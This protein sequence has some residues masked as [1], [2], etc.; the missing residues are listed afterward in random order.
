M[1]FI[2]FFLFLIFWV[3]IMSILSIFSCINWYDHVFFFFYWQLIWWIDWLLNIEQALHSWDKRHMS[4]IFLLRHCWIR[5][6]NI[7]WWLFHLCSWGLLVCSFFL[8]DSLQGIFGW[9]CYQGNAHLKNWV[10]KHS[11][12]GKRH[13][14][15]G[16]NS[17]LNV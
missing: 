9:A 10:G 1:P 8:P 15:I 3:F 11:I 7:F 6:A 14:R 13:C 17:S 16:V 4:H 12:F 5:F 2:Y